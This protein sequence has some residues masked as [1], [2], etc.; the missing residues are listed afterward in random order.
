MD[1]MKYLAVIRSVELGNF[2]SAAEVLH[3]TQSAVSRMVKNLEDVWGIT[4]LERG[5]Y[6]V[7]LTRD[8]LAVYPLLQRICNE[9]QNL[10]NQIGEL[11]NFK[12]GQIRIG[13]ISSIATH[14]LPPLLKT[15]KSLHPDVSCELILGDYQEITE[16]IRMGK[17]DFGFLRLP[18]D[19]D[20]DIQV[21]AQDDFQVVLPIGHPLEQYE[22]IAYEQLKPYPF[23]L[24]SRTT[25]AEVPT[26]LQENLSSLSIRYRTWDDYAVMAMVEQ[27]LGIGILPKLVLKR[28]AYS[29][30]IRPLQEK[31]FRTLVVAK[32][33]GVPQSV[34]AARFLELLTTMALA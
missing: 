29:L 12:I 23:I 14:W 32:R 2:T 7:K 5:K 33:K 6:G 26:L 18:V 19:E 17:V 8:G 11:T 27:N 1:T 3:C 30:S 21:L 15:F 24:L 16:W 9:Q 22:R 31:A 13:T 28:C 34:A 4:L 20:L 10:E 25:K